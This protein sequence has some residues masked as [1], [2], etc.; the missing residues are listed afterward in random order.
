MRTVVSQHEDEAGLRASLFHDTPAGSSAYEYV[1]FRCAGETAPGERV[2]LVV[3]AG[4]QRIS[5][6]VTLAARRQVEAPNQ[7]EYLARVEEG[8][9]VWLEMMCAKLRTLRR[10]AA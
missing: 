10:F 6:G 8:D 9:R 4:A 3:C 2:K 1:T 5:V 7:W